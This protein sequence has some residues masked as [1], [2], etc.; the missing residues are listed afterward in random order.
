MLR[1]LILVTSI[2]ATLEACVQQPHPT[3]RQSIVY[4]HVPCGTPGA[5]REVPILLD[6]PP[7][8]GSKPTTPLKDRPATCV[9][10]RAQ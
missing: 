5:L 4:I 8:G 6:D 10:E 3:P 1:R 9:I 2:L 7:P